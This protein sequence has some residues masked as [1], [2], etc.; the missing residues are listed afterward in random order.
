MRRRRGGRRRAS[1][2]GAPVRRLPSRRGHGA[3]RA[4]RSSASAA[5]RGRPAWKAA[6]AQRTSSS[7][8]SGIVGR[9]ELERSGEPRLGLG[10]IEAERALAGEREEA[11]SR[12]GELLGL[13]RVAG[14]RG[15]LERLQVVMGEHLGQVLDPLACLALDPGGRRAVTARP[16]R[17]RD[18]AV[19]DVAHEQ[20]PERVLALPLHRARPGGADELLAG[21][22]VQRQLELARV[23]AAHL[24]Q[25]ARPEHLPEHGRVLEQALA[26]GE[27]VSRRAAISACKLSGSAAQGIS[28]ARGRGLRAGARTPPRRAGCHPP[29][30]GSSARARG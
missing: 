23:A 2:A 1:G 9:G 14:G 27:S 7:G 22:L 6:S 19:G 13:L 21:K 11:A 28:P 29:A 3:R 16:L 25:R 20:V 15:E 18:L 5:S 30:R 26:L 12:R 17:P 10:R 8:R 4:P 24:G